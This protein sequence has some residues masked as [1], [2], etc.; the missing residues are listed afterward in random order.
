MEKQALGIKG[1]WIQIKKILHINLFF[2]T[3][4]VE[5]SGKTTAEGSVIYMQKSKSDSLWD[6]FKSTGN[7]IVYNEYKKTEAMERRD[8]VYNNF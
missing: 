2:N 3:V 1:T 7:P 8:N 5:F 6:I 4:F